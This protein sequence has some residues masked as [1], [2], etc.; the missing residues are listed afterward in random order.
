LDKFKRLV[1]HVNS[2]TMNLK[3]REGYRHN[4][5][6]E[7]I[8]MLEATPD[9]EVKDAGRKKKDQSIDDGRRVGSI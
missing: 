3:L 2:V 4:L 7:F 1:E 5:T 9:K 6:K 8:K